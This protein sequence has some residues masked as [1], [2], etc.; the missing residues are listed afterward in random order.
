[1]HKLRYESK[2]REKGVVRMRNFADDR[3][4]R[5]VDKAVRGSY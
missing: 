4:V 2:E 3:H 5:H 1:M